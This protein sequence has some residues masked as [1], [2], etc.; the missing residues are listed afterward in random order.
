MYNSLIHTQKQKRAT[1]A[2]VSC[3]K[4][5]QQCDDE[6]PCGRCKRNG[7]DCDPVDSVEALAPQRKR[8]PGPAQ[9]QTP[10]GGSTPL[11]DTTEPPC[12]PLPACLKQ[13]RH[14][15]ARPIVMC[16]WST[17]HNTDDLVRL[18]NAFPGSI[19]VAMIMPATMRAR[20]TNQTARETN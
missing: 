15:W 11:L 12:E 5:K 14:A 20:E 19:E 3:R 9:F 2:C 6:R 4:S 13:L 16:F 10:S 18:L 7:R 17:G 8:P 1:F